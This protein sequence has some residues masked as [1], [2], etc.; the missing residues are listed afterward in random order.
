MLKVMKN[1]F[2]QVPIYITIY[3]YRIYK[4]FDLKKKT[5]TH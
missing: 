3:V 1:L 2:E 5:I 4:R